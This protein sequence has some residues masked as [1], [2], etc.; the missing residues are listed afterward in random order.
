MS[1]MSG[2]GG[3][4]G[5]PEMGGQ[6]IV[7]P[8]PL[9]YG[10]QQPYAP[11]QQAQQQQYAPLQPPQYAQPQQYGPQQPYGS[12]QQV[13]QFSPQQ[14]GPYIPQQPPP[15]QAQQQ[16]A[17]L[18]P[19]QYAQ[20]QPQHVPQP[21]QQPP[22]QPQSHYPK[23]MGMDGIP[24]N[25]E[26]DFKNYAQKY[27]NSSGS[28]HPSASMP[29]QF[30]QAQGAT[31]NVSPTNTQSDTS[32]KLDKMQTIFDELRKELSKD[33]N[34][35]ISP[36]IKNELELEHQLKT[37]KK[38]N[39]LILELQE[40]I[41][42][43]KK[44]HDAAMEKLR[45]EIDKKNR[46]IVEIS[47]EHKNKSA[48]SEESAANGEN[49]K[50]Y[51]DEITK[52][53][54]E[55]QT[56]ENE[57][58]ELHRQLQASLEA[59]SKL[60]ARDSELEQ[61]LTS[62]KDIKIIE[63]KLQIAV[64]E[65]KKL[66]VEQQK[67][68]ADLKE[69]LQ[70]LESTGNVDEMEAMV[71]KLQSLLEQSQSDA[72]IIKSEKERMQ[73]RFDENMKLLQSKCDTASRDLE[74]IKAGYNDALSALQAENRDLQIKLQAQQNLQAM[75]NKPPQGGGAPPS[76]NTMIN[77]QNATDITIDY[78][79]I[80][81]KIKKIEELHTFL[82]KDYKKSKE[83]N[84]KTYIKQYHRNFEGIKKVLE[85][86]IQLEKNKNKN[87]KELKKIKTELWKYYSELYDM[88]LRIKEI[89]Q[90]KNPE[91]T[92]EW[93][94][95]KG[96]DSILQSIDEN[97]SKRFTDFKEK[98]DTENSNSVVQEIIEKI[99]TFI[100]FIIVIACVIMVILNILNIIRYLYECFKEIG[101]LNH[102]NLSTGD[103]FRYKLF[104]YLFY[105]DGCSIP[106][107]INQYNTPGAASG[108]II[109]LSQAISRFTLDFGNFFQRNSIEGED[110]YAFKEKVF[111][112]GHT[113]LGQ[114]LNEGLGNFKRI[115]DIT[116][117]VIDSQRKAYRDNISDRRV[118]DWIKNE[119]KNHP[120]IDKKDPEAVRDF[121]ADEYKNR[122]EKEYSETV[123]NNNEPF[124]S[125]FFML[126]L[127]FFAIRLVITI[128]NIFFVSTLILIIL[129]LINKDNVA[130]S[131]NIFP[132]FNDTNILTIFIIS[133]FFVI[134]NIILY[135]FMYLKIYEN[136][137]NT[138]L[139]IYSID[140]KITESIT[141]FNT[142][143][144]E[145]IDPTAQEASTGAGDATGAQT[146][147]KKKT[148]TYID[149][150][151]Y[152]DLKDNID[153]KKAILDHIKDIIEP[154][155]A[156]AQTLTD[157]EI[158]NKCTT[159]IMLYVLV[160]HIYNSFEK[161]KN[162]HLDVLQHFLRDPGDQSESINFVDINGDILIKKTYYSF[163]GSKF[164]NESIQY[165]ED[166][167]DGLTDI[168]KFNKIKVNVNKNIEEL[169][170]LIVLVNNQFYDDY[171]IIQFG[172]YFLV[173]LVISV[174]Y[175]VALMSSA[176]KIPTICKIFSGK[177][178]GSD[179]KT[180]NK[181]DNVVTQS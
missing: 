125:I 46:K 108:T 174:I 33:P 32:T 157:D 143:V 172:V 127:N 25:S 148:Q 74:R 170:D 15:Q 19:P 34:S 43:Q 176:M 55:K 93:P 28:L 9:G 112:L 51:T 161:R 48:K 62:D 73:Y 87:D 95:T 160:L 91:K 98:I 47:N 167:I 96:I 106:A 145:L 175:I 109:T 115:D 146:Q 42:T 63:E 162:S 132:L 26:A 22:Q 69:K 180:A 131:E 44:A 114:G 119:S 13:P 11:S 163:I 94:I 97:V 7:Q 49:T 138:Y 60:D 86:I 121:L 23:I 52:L 12:P 6:Q 165:F 54:N 128:I 116:E 129:K 56:L 100:I 152:V 75:S 5:M 41:D 4:G 84:L 72:M 40:E 2:M 58:N 68:I 18:Q 123:D 103:T 70:L 31:A 67:E 135:K 122:L 155:P 117:S 144:D 65:K 14:G 64:A 1:R 88:F 39:E 130:K 80:N 85:R 118:E 177:D 71:L 104:N 168:E 57:K 151:F 169:N 76:S 159:Y 139:Y 181:H 120:E 37:A 110:S 136:Q 29:M 178:C 21:P 158:T 105:I 36:V 156:S 17:P 35:L 45:E 179:Q 141:K 53:K 111:D 124:F 89:I 107:I 133:I 82:K 99:F 92:E 173:N 77:T 113:A 38:Q 150:K 126:R 79:F 153:N 81:E 142:L 59:K 61:E 78:N 3:M 134:I 30:Q 10:L 90:N 27:I 154:S 16:Y 66:E 171:Y 164:R 102:N 137:L 83:E 24:I 8:S 101:N 149:R 50:K 140:L 147:P 166:D 20:S